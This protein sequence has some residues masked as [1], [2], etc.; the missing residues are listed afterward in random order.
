MSA[1]V[2]ESGSLK[3]EHTALLSTKRHD[4]GIYFSQP[5]DERKFARL[6]AQMQAEA[7]SDFERWTLVK[8]AAAVNYFTSKQ[9][10][11]LARRARILSSLSRAHNVQKAVLT[12]PRTLHASCPPRRRSPSRPRCSSR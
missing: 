3:L 8:M 1:Q 7:L 5:M 12:R 11:A 10:R 2:P 4:R 6:R 9:V